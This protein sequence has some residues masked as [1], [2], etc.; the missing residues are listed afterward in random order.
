[1]LKIQY[2]G[3]TLLISVGGKKILVV[4]DLHLGYEETLNKTGV[5][6]SRKLFE[7]V[8]EEFDKIFEFIGGKY[9]KNRVRKK[10]IAD[11]TKGL[12]ENDGDGSDGDNNRVMDE[13]VLLGDV[14][15]VFGTVLEQEWRDV[16][17]LI[18]YFG[19]KL[20]KNGKIIITKGNHDV[21]LGP[22]L[23]GKEGV[24][25]VDNYIVDG[26][27]F[28]HGDKDYEEIWT[29]KIKLIIIGHVH[30]AVR[31]RDRDG[32]KEEKYKCFLS[33]KYKERNWIIVPSFAE[34]SEGMDVRDV[35]GIEI[36]RK[37][38]LMKFNVIVVDPMGLETRDFGK[39][40]KLE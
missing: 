29:D 1:M 13:I 2:I 33:G 11:K 8:I 16:L 22:I 19:K 38:D 24:K 5:F 7:E 18:D 21:T 25:L 36:L 35:D 40:E 3:K 31:I 4:G 10:K 37:I 28:I 26:L 15:H 27:C 34:Y 6:V 9:G 14:K 32:I 39:L 17:K 30:P 20:K 23:K 12:G